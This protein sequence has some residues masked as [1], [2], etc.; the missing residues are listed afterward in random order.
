MSQIADVETEWVNNNLNHSAV[1]SYSFENIDRL[2][3]STKVLKW[4]AFPDVVGSFSK[5]DFKTQLGLGAMIELGYMQK[6]AFQAR[7]AVGYTNAVNVAYSPL[8]QPKAYFS[9]RLSKS[10][11]NYLY[12][13]IRFRF[14]YRPIKEVE[15]QAGID[16]HH[17]GE[18][19]RSL[20]AGYQSAPSPFVKMKLNLWRFEYHFTQQLWSQGMFT[21]QY[22]PIGNASHYLSY[23]INK[24][25][26]VG[27]FETVVYG[28]KDSIY[29]RG[30][31][32]EYMNPFV[33][34]R[35]QEFG[36]GSPDNVILG[37]DASYQI[38]NHMVYGSF[39]L[40]EFLLSEIRARRRWWA[41]KYAGQIGV[42]SHFYAGDHHFFH[43]FEATLVR[44]FTFTQRT[45]D[46]VYGN[47][48]LPIAHPL[49]ANFIELYDELNWRYKNFDFT[50]Y[51]QYYLK[52]ESN[53]DVFTGGDIF[54]SYNARKE[55]YN[56][57][58]GSGK[59]TWRYAAGL[60]LA[61][62]LHQNKWQVFLEPRLLIDKV[63]K[64]LFYNGF[65]T[66]GIHRK[67][68]SSRRNY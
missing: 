68:G 67:I 56:F 50:L 7:Y 27:F 2:F 31:S 63:E 51:I 34:F 43:R 19:D 30:I 58:I 32:L 3:D 29:N 52:G 65:V 11:Q 17:I 33:M 54:T 15:L 9:N 24:N 40:D 1:K 55:Q 12:N 57:T 49:G 18:G 21:K 46:A 23:K 38:G 59:T 22:I 8:L 53:G 13:D 20:M 28:M 47:D 66:V 39:V 5:N 26:H 10:G 6:I 16:N 64:S 62:G 41:N 25:F 14:T 42:K 60:H 44:P 45:I 35:P 37:L 61:Y 4:D 48:A 36:I